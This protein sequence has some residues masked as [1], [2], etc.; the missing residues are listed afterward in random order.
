MLDSRLEVLG[1]QFARQYDLIKGVLEADKKKYSKLIKKDIDD[2]EIIEM[3]AS[4]LIQIT[5]L[6]P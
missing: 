4:K 3:M 2:K 5:A 6:K 1:V